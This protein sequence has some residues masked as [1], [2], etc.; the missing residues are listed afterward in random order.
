MGRLKTL[1]LELEAITPLWMGGAN[2]RPELRAPSV[3]GLMRFWFRALAGSVLDMD[4]MRTAEAAVFGRAGR[5]SSVAVRL[6]GA[7]RTGRSPVAPGEFPGVAY[8]HWSL[9]QR[10]RDAILPGERFQLRLQTRPLALAPVEV[11]GCVMTPDDCLSLAAA[12]VWLLV[13]LGGVGARARRCA[14]TI[15]PLGEPEGWPADLPPLTSVAGTPGELAG[16]I[17]AGLKQIGQWTGWPSHMP[18]IPSP[19]NI[20]HPAVAQIHVVDRTFPSWWEAVDWAGQTFQTFRRAQ[21]DDAQAVAG[22]LTRGRLVARTIQRAALGLPL[23]FFF[24][25]MFQAMTSEGVDPRDARSRASATVSPRR[26]QARASPL[27]FRVVRLAGQ[28]PAYAVVM[29]LFRA[30]FLPENQ[31]TIRPQQRGA[32]FVDVS[33]PENYQIVD[34]W[35]AHVAEQHAPLLDVPLS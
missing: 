22:L 35:F 10:N 17:S 28:P 30:R 13:R 3:R 23:V 25:S 34:R 21:V 20:L 16:E 15:A 11:H 29:L 19:Y 2:Y 32:R 8:M 33:V 26:G 24:K 6:R 1:D 7:V 9:Y 27:I 31:M 4:E 12:S 5:A 14:G 18:E